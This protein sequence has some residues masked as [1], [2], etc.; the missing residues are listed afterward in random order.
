MNKKPRPG[1]HVIVDGSTGASTG[2]TTINATLT[3]TAVAQ[4]AAQAVTIATD[5]LL[6]FEA[7]LQT[8]ALLSIAEVLGAALTTREELIA[9][10][11]DC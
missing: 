10:L 1:R 7:R 11:D 4:Q 6:L 2:D 5:E 9:A 3:T 8:Q